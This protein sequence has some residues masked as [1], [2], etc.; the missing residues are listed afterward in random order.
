MAAPVEDRLRRIASRQN[1]LLKEVR[2][3]LAQAELTPAG[4]CAIEGSKTVEEAIRSGLKF[5][6]IIF[7]DSGAARLASRLLAQ[8]R[9]NVE[10]VVVD[11]EIFRGVV[12][13]ENPQGVVALA[14]PPEFT[15]EELLEGDGSILLAS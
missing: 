11:D 4:D 8:L 1:A 12:S 13:T 14:K 9:A 7:S 3:A 6:A 2:R 15:V 5:R 10:A